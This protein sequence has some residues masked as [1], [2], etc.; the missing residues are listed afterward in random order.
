[1]KTAWA[2]ACFLAVALLCIGA[3]IAHA[4]DVG[5]NAAASLRARYDGLQNQLSRNQFKRPLYMDSSE[6]SDSAT[7]DIYACINKM[8]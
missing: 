4:D 3:R 1:M 8:S 6:T 7:G 2:S 5:A